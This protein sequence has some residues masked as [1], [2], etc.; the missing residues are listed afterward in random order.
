[1]QLA[2]RVGEQGKVYAEDID[3]SALRHLSRRCEKWNLQNVQAILGEIDHPQLPSAELDV[4]FIISSYHHFDDPITLLKNARS[5]LK[6]QGVLA[7]G[8][9]IPREGRQGYNT[10]E[11]ME[12]QMKQAGYKLDRIETLLEKNFMYIYIFKLDSPP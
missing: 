12:A 2:V 5:A 1:M 4:I 8:E 9:W 6:P 3:A 10:P 11:Q 7:I